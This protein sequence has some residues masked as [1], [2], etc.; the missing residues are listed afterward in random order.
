MFVCGL[1]QLAFAAKYLLSMACEVIHS[2]QQPYRV[3]E[4]RYA[5][6][7]ESMPYLVVWLSDYSD[8]Q[9]LFY[10]PGHPSP[11]NKSIIR[12]RR[13]ESFLALSMIDRSLAYD[14]HSLAKFALGLAGK[15][16]R[17]A[18]TPRISFNQSLSSLLYVFLCYVDLSVS[19]RRGQT[20]LL[21][22]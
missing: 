19:T 21:I 8:K 9:R 13:G 7:G 14:H 3:H 12:H 17:S 18:A 20:K 2:I 4:K 5:I 16:A 22:L 11:F 1:T 10:D 15:I 6:L